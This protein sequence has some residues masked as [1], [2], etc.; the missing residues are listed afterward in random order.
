MDHTLM[1]LSNIDALQDEIFPFSSWIPFDPSTLPPPIFRDTKYVRRGIK[2]G[3][4]YKK[5]FQPCHVSLP[6]VS[7]SVG[8]Y[9]LF[10][11]PRIYLQKS[12]CVP[13]INL[14][15]YPGDYP[16]F[17]RYIYGMYMTQFPVVYIYGGYRSLEENCFMINIWS[18][19]TTSR[20]PRRLKR[21][22]QKIMSYLE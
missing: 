13:K 21:K 1:Y 10:K 5:L 6:N 19:S 18:P 9:R 11:K 16:H 3:R 7:K 2:Y 8:H 15:L 12:T 20:P 22:C 14:R 17:D 4:T